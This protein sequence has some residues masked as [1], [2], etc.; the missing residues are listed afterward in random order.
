MTYGIGWVAGIALIMVACSGSTDTIATNKLADMPIDQA[1]QIIASKEGLDSIPRATW[2]QLL[3]SEQY[4]IL[5]ENGTEK[6]FT[7][8]YVKN[9]AQGTY[10]TA[11]CK[12]P[13][14][15]SQHK[16]KSGTGWPSFWE[17]VDKENIILKTDSRWGMKRTEILSKCGEHL[18]HVFDDGPEPTGLRYCINSAALVFVPEE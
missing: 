8:E 16:F 7:G 14:F 11:G 18:G 3:T 2:R 13:V 10:V 9:K 5:W 15:H 6:A 4:H 17:T 1:K 12:I